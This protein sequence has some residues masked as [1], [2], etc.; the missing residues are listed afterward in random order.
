[1]SSDY[2]RFRARND[3][4]NRRAEERQRRSADE[5]RR[6]RERE[7]DR[8]DAERRHR[9][10]L[11][12]G[13]PGGGAGS[14]GT[15]PVSGLMLLLF[16]GASGL[17]Y[18][19][20]SI[21][22]APARQHDEG[23]AKGAPTA[24]A[25]VAETGARA[26]SDLQEAQVARAGASAPNTVIDEPTGLARPLASDERVESADNQGTAADQVPVPDDPKVGRATVRALK[27]GDSAR[28]S[29]SGASGYV[30][31]SAVQEYADREC[32]NVS[33]SVIQGESQ[34]ISQ[35]VTWCRPHGGEWAKAN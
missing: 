31:V 34:L 14:G 32:R 18:L 20:A 28:W 10:R 16:L 1:M 7:Q 12:A 9:E 6:Q 30:V 33:Y 24:P 11:R 23:K 15:L 2:D 27:S 35:A 17:M 3:E 13:D 25:E 4:I 5:L 8:R 26:D 21:A 29:A 19:V 22:G